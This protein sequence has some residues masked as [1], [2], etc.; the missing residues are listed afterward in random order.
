M[1]VTDPKQRASLQEIM[2]HPWMIKGFGSPP[3]NYLPHREPLQLPLDPAVIQAMTGFDFGAPNVIE[4]Q[5]TEVIESQAYQR[6][7]RLAMQE[8]ELQAAPKDPEKKRAFNFDFYK[9]RNSST[10][11]DNLTAPSLEG[12]A[13]GTDPVNA[14]HPLISVYYLVREKQER[15]R[16]N[17]NAVVTGVPRSPGEAPLQMADLAAP[18]PA[19]T[20]AATYEMPG[21]QATGGRSRPRA[22]THG[23][24]EVVDAVKHIKI[25]GSSNPASPA[26]VEP[27]PEPPHNPPT[28]YPLKK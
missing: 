25:S 10:S 21:E 26:I 23:E 15:D 18:K 22:R 13:L 3:E 19:H 9:R 8:K 16:R 24:D 12:L 27:P 11:R 28:H 17:A 2:N 20:N 5:L 14:Y 4:A 7:V 1:L 6:A